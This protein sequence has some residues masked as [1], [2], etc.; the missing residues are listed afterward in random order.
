MTT[1]NPSVSFR[2]HHFG[3]DKPE[4]ERP[5]TPK[6][7]QPPPVACTNVES[8]MTAYSGGDE[9]ETHDQTLSTG[10]VSETVPCTSDFMKGIEF[11]DNTRTP[12]QKSLKLRVPKPPRAKSAPNLLL[13]VAQLITP[14]ERSLMEHE[15]RK[16]SLNSSRLNTLITHPPGEHTRNQN[17]I[18]RLLSFCKPLTSCCR[19]DDNSEKDNSYD[20]KTKFP[21]IKS[22]LFSSKKRIII[23]LER[24]VIVICMKQQRKTHATSFRTS[25]PILDN[26]INSFQLAF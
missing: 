17:H 23:F 13:S 15:L 10:C 25:D 4:T 9:C 14:P 6:S 8:N 7:P 18:M 2:F 16:M 19:P 20:N 1:L 3:Y 12:S 5:I 24:Y 26:L 21:H 11:D 22:G